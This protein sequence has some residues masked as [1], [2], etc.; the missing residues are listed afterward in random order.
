MYIYIIH[1]I[2]LPLSYLYYIYP[3]SSRDIPVKARF[4]HRI[5]AA[6]GKL[7]GCQHADETEVPTPLYNSIFAVATTGAPAAASYA[8]LK[9]MPSNNRVH[10]QII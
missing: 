5:S 10:Q 6:V 3:R 2:Y 4:R 1:N 7:L 8:A 9:G